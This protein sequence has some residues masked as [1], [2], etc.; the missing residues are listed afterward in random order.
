MT[1][2]KQEMRSL[3]K[4][5]AMACAVAL[6]GFAEL[7]TATGVA[8]VGPL[9]ANMVISNVPGGRERLYLAGAPLAGIFPISAIAMSVGLNVTFTS[10]HDRMDFGFVG[11]GAVMHDL[12][13]LAGCMHEAYVELRTAAARKRRG[14]N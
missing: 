14:R 11:N 5:A 7:E 8:Q 13:V 10:W 6:L 4:D 3:S 2:A 12:P 9:L 1:S